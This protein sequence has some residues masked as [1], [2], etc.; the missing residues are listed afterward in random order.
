M[1]SLVAAK[2]PVI[3][4]PLTTSPSGSGTRKQRSGVNEP[5]LLHK[6][7]VTSRSPAA[8]CSTRPGSRFATGCRRTPRWKRSRARLARLLGLENRVG[9]IE[10]GRDADLLALDGRPLELTTIDSMDLGGW[11]HPREG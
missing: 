4:G 5:G 9:T 8:T 7:G 1:R 6:A 10:A 2:V 3:L 11:H